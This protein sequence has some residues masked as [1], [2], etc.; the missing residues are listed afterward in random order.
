MA[1]KCGGA[2]GGKGGG[3]CPGG[4]CAAPAPRP[5]VAVAYAEPVYV[6][7]NASGYYGALGMVPATYYVATGV[8]PGARLT[9]EEVALA[10]EQL[11]QQR[12]RELRQEGRDDAAAARAA[13]DAEAQRVAT[14]VAG[15]IRE[16]GQIA[17]AG[18]GA[19]R[20]TE[21]ARINA[22]R[23]EAVAR[24]R[25]EVDVEREQTR[26]AEIERGG[27]ASTGTGTGEGSGVAV[28]VGV[29][30]VAGVA[31]YVLTRKGGRRRRR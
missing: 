14:G 23:D 24:H 13:R 20:D 8:T 1:C 26:R 31:Y 3:G 10:R 5:R 22:A 30:V 7:E 4:V 15:G 21:I 28:V 18:I 17:S 9:P 27:F 2:C 11:R 12:E 19:A 29:V 16:A 25:S 6:A